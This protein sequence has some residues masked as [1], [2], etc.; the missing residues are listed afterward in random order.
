MV[1]AEAGE[2]GGVDAG[3]AAALDVVIVARVVGE[4]GGGVYAVL[5][6]T[7]DELAGAEDPAGGSAT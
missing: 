2:D 3:V 4:L 6:D 1:E 5:D 7:R